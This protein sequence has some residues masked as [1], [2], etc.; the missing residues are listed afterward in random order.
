MKMKAVIAAIFLSLVATGA[1]AQNL[2]VIGSRPA[3]CPH[4][5]CGC[6]ASIY[7]FGKIIPSLNLAL[8]WRRFPSSSP[9]PRMAAY[10]P[11]HVMV[12]VSHVSG[13]NWVVHDGNSGGGKTRLHVRS[14]RGFRVVNPSGSSFGGASFASIPSFGG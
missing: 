14:I 1:Q 4:R 6:S 11:G 12:L 5:Y 7:L 13:D 10:R 9:A 2:G 8:N 3:G